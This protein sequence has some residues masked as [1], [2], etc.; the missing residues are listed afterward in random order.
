ML[1]KIHKS[2]VKLKYGKKITYYSLYVDN[3]SSK[4]IMGTKKISNLTNSE[5]YFTLDEKMKD[6]SKDN[7]IGKLVA[8]FFGNEYN[9]Y[10]VSENNNDVFDENSSKILG[11]I[12]YV[13]IY[14]L[15]IRK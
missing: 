5:Y 3:L 2:S 9:I 1:C 11:T 10:D 15:I 7:I 4:F 14:Y 6:F 8:K 12:E 13:K